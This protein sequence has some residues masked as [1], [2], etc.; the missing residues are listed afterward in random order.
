MVGA[1]H[2]A[3]PVHE[4]WVSEF[5]VRSDDPNGR[6]DLEEAGCYSMMCLNGIDNAEH[7]SELN[8][9]DTAEWMRCPYF[10]RS[11]SWSV[12]QAYKL[13]T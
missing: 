8:V 3:N 7:C 6:L 2:L 5:V 10:Y 1:L 12:V 9:Y 11:E 4:K 13:M